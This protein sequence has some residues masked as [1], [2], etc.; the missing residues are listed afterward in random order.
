MKILAPNIDF[1]RRF[2]APAAH[3]ASAFP[4]SGFKIA[5]RSAGHAC[6]EAPMPC[7]PAALVIEEFALSSQFD[8]LEHAAPD[9]P[10]FTLA[11]DGL[12]F[13]GQFSRPWHT[14][15]GN[16]FLCAKIPF[17]TAFSEDGWAGE[18]SPCAPMA[19]PYGATPSTGASAPVTPPIPAFNRFSIFQAVPC[20]AVIRALRAC[21][22]NFTPSL[23][24]K[25]ANDIILAL[26]RPVKIGGCLT[27]I[28]LAPA[29]VRFGIGVNLV[30]APPPD[31]TNSLPPAAA[32]PNLM[33]ESAAPG[34][35]ERVVAHMIPEL[36]RLTKI[37][38]DSPERI[39]AQ[40][41]AGRL[42]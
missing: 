7:D 3:P 37:A 14:A 29:A 13:H 25:F 30:S 4:D 16:L 34:M 24:I 6:F 23:G 42:M 40:Y 28:S 22:Q 33:P 21:S 41:N 26:P 11:L 8:R 39:A 18:V 35:L 5:D 1:A 19:P 10:L 38:A 32:I 15:P 36:I 31:A 17:A 27:S 2:G 9:R 20:L 12:G